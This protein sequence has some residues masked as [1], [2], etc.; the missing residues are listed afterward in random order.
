MECLQEE[1][2]ILKMTLME[3]VD[4]LEAIIGEPGA[5]ETPNLISI[6]ADLNERLSSLQASHNRDEH[7][8]LVS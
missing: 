1:E 7:D 8:D 4:R 5:E 3:C 6:C 2:L